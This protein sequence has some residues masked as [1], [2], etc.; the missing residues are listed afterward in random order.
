MEIDIR[1]FRTQQNL[2]PTWGV[3]TFQP[4]AFEGLARLSHAGDSLSQL[5]QAV[6]DVL[7]ETL[8]WEAL[9]PL[10]DTLEQAFGRTLTT[11]NTHIGLRAVEIGFAVAG[12]SDMLQACAYEL[13]YARALRH[14]LPLASSIYQAWLTKSEHLQGDT[15]TYIHHTTP[16]Q[17][18]VVSDVYGRCGLVVRIGTAR[19]T[20]KDTTYRCPAE[21][22][23][24][25]LFLEV[26]EHIIR[27]L[28]HETANGRHHAP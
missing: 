1:T 14:P 8:S 19:Y 2:P 16:W 26:V 28:T 13:L 15:F 11:V 22:F 7:P 27:A 24:Q 23:M 21:P 17:V 6:C 25:R 4:K 9:L 10:C 18:Q 5:R 3:A 20:L 12:W